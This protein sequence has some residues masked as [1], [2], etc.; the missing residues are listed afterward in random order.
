M[1]TKTTIRALVLV[2]GLLA[3]LVNT[4]NAKAETTFVT[5]GA[6][7]TGGTYGIIAAA[8]AK[9]VN[10]SVDRVRMTIES[11]PG[12]GRGNIRLLG[13]KKID[14]GLATVA[15]AVAAFR[16]TG[17]FEGAKLDNIRILLVGTNL[18][19]HVVVA[20]DSGVSS[21]AQLK[22]KHLVTNSSANALTFVPDALSGYGLTKGKDYELT[23]YSTTEAMEAFKDGRVEGFA[24][25]LFMPASALVE[26]ATTRDVRFLE[27]DKTHLDKFVGKYEIYSRSTIPAGTYPGQDKDLMTPAIA[28]AIFTHKDVDAQ[29]VYQVA[30]A[31]LDHREDLAKIYKPATSFSVDR[32]RAWA[33]SAM[34]PPYHNGGARLLRD[35]GILN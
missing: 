35:I 11:T 30:K 10:S 17:A 31:I 25:F 26:V 8:V 33:T 2:S 1:L 28:V 19:L 3:L 18:P 9:V 23:Q 14:F 15:D 5:I 27:Y 32:Q 20:D 4:E 13:R 24:S 34:I 12:G 16:G 21:I 6:S 22:G 29:L 7:G